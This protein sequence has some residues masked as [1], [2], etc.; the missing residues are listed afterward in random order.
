MH[1]MLK[2]K[3]FNNLAA[4]FYYY[5]FNISQLSI[6]SFQLL[7]YDLVNNK[8]YNVHSSEHNIL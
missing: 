1:E 4:L 6:T 3:K 7:Y 5:Q 2:F 8:I